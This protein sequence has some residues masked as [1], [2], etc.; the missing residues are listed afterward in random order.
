MTFNVLD[1][2]PEDPLGILPTSYV[3]GPSPRPLMGLTLGQA[4]DAAAQRWGDIEAL[5]S[6]HQGQRFS[7]A[8][9]RTQADKSAR[10]FLALG[11]T[12]GDRVAIWSPNCA[13]W[14]ARR[15]CSR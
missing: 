14:L 8:E 3:S 11:L 12:K 2:R 4:L 10:A 5:V 7:Y 9:L 1:E 15:Y 6:R 13:E